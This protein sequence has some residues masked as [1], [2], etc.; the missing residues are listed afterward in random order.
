MGLYPISDAKC[1]VHQGSQEGS[2]CKTRCEW[3]E[4][5]YEHWDVG[6]YEGHMHKIQKVQDMHE[7]QD[8]W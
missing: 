4:K 7:V 6:E 2:N 3:Q 5:N 1:V 8:V